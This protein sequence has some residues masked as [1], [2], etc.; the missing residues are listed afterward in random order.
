MQN[1]RGSKSSHAVHVMQVVIGLLAIG[2]KLRI[3]SQMTWMSRDIKKKDS[4]SKLSS[5]TEQQRRVALRLLQA[6]RGMH[7]MSE[8]SHRDFSSKLS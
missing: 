6:T 8:F 1:V 3:T 4:M 7:S 5:H 2:A